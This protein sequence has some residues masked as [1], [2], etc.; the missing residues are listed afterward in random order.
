[1][2]ASSGTTL[3]AALFGEKGA[4]FSEQVASMVVRLGLF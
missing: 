1:M 4:F 3:M 2:A